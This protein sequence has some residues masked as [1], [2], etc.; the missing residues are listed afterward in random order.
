MSATKQPKPTAVKPTTP[1]VVDHAAQLRTSR[2]R[3][4]Q[5]QREES[6]IAGHIRVAIL[7]EDGGRVSALT[8]RQA[9]LPTLIARAAAALLPLEEAALDAETAAIAAQEDAHRAVTDQA[10]AACVAARDAFFEAERRYNVAKAD[11]QMYP[12][13]REDITRQRRALRDRLGRLATADEPIPA[14]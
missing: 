5:L 11:L 7:A 12:I 6:E 2:D 8:A 3:L 13:R 14:A 1:T 10:E 9:M 4:A